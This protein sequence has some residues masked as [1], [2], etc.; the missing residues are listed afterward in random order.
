MSIFIIC[1]ILAIPFALSGLFFVYLLDSNTKRMTIGDVI[2]ALLLSSIP[3]GNVG[4]AMFTWFWV[5]VFAVERFGIIRLFN[6]LMS[7]TLWTKRAK[8]TQAEHAYPMET[9]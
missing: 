9:D 3:F 5:I 2:V 4:V 8:K 6:R 1:S 7:V